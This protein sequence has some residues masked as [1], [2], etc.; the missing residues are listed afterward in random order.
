MFDF[1]TELQQVKKEIS[2]GLSSVLIK[3]HFLNI[4]LLEGTSLTVEITIQGFR[5]VD[6]TDIYETIQGLLFDFSPLF[7]QRFHSELCKKL[8][9][10]INE[11]L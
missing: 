6:T 5:V 3:D 2:F 8:E 7:K 10:V 9:Y 11:N 4:I 1:D